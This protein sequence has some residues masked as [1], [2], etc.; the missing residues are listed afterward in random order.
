MVNTLLGVAAWKMGL[1]PDPAG[2]GNRVDYQS[3]SRD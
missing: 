1:D 2:K 3:L